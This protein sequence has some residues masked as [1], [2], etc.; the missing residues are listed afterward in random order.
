MED[1]EFITRILEKKIITLFL[2]YDRK[3]LRTKI[4]Y[5][6]FFMALQYGAEQSFCVKKCAFEYYTYSI[7]CKNTYGFRYNIHNIYLPQKCKYAKISEILDRY[8]NGRMNDT[9]VFISIQ[10]SYCEDSNVDLGWIIKGLKKRNSFYT[11]LHTIFETDFLG[12]GKQNFLSELFESIQNEYVDNF[13]AMAANFIKDTE[14]DGVNSI[15]CKYKR[16]FYVRMK[17]Y[18]Y[19]VI[20]DK[21]GCIKKQEPRRVEEAQRNETTQWQN[22][23]TQAN[24][25]RRR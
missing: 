21:Y 13:M 5:K 4:G 8:Y 18:Y 20:R 3:Q 6:P 24:D 2:I 17:K 9:M 25:R 10:N 11:E 22:V 16:D 14:F 19:D 12:K 15:Q 1:I 23:D 7:T